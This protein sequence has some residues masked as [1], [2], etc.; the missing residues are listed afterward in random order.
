MYGE[1]LQLGG[2]VV[3]L[4]AGG[5]I[6]TRA[7]QAAAQ[8]LKD[9]AAIPYWNSVEINNND[10]IEPQT[11]DEK[12]SAAYYK[13]ARLIGK[14]ALSYIG[15]SSSI[16]GFSIGTMIPAILPLSNNNNKMVQSGKVG[17]ALDRSGSMVLTQVNNKLALNLENNLLNSIGS[18][19]NHLIVDVTSQDTASIE[20]YTKAINTYPIEKANFYKSINELLSLSQNIYVV[21]NGHGFSSSNQV[22][23]IT[24]E[25]KKKKQTI[26]FYNLSNTENTASSQMKEIAK[27]TDGEYL[28]S[29]NSFTAFSD[30]IKK[31]LDKLSKNPNNQAGS[32]DV[33]NYLVI[34]GLAAAA[35]FIGYKKRSKTIIG[36]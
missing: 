7:K 5:Y 17:L 22:S 18:L 27:S 23:N 25:A 10:K 12:K 31:R 11:L 15:L 34:T 8:E 33:T 20:T 35:T 29:K 3:G 30:S 1:L 6:E 2:L 14:N 21:S 9:L 4:G 16:I 13:S 32:I 26:S 28:S 36:S 19:S 24:A